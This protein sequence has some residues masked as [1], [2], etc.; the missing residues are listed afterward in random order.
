MRILDAYPYP[1]DILLGREGQ[2]LRFLDVTKLLPLHIR[3]RNHV[4]PIICTI[5]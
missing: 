3:N 4:R 5:F 2:L 1:F